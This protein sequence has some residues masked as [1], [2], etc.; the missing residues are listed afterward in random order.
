MQ[1]LKI[2]AALVPHAQDAV[3][4]FNDRLAHFCGTAQGS[5]A[6]FFCAAFFFEAA[7]ALFLGA[8]LGFFDGAANGKNG[9][10]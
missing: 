3:E 8:L 5:L 6:R 4:Q 10:L 9:R 7:Q 2:R 1:R